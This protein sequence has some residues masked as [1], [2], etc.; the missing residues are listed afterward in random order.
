MM[1]KMAVENPQ[2]VNE[3]LAGGSLPRGA[4]TIGG[5]KRTDLL[6]QA[7]L[8]LVT[9]EQ[10]APQPAVVDMARSLGLQ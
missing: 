6:E 8:G 9:D 1:E 3:L 5:G 2:L 7:A 10:M 4:Y